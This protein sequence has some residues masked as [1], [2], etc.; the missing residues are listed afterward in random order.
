MQEGLYIIPNDEYSNYLESNLSA[1]HKINYKDFLKKK[2]AYRTKSNRPSKT[3]PDTSVQDPKLKEYKS[4]LRRDR[5]LSIDSVYE[6]STSFDA[7]EESLENSEALVVH[8]QAKRYYFHR[9]SIQSRSYIRNRARDYLAKIKP[10]PLLLSADPDLGVPIDEL[11]KSLLNNTIVREKNSNFADRVAKYQKGNSLTEQGIDGRT[12][13]S[14]LETNPLDSKQNLRYNTLE[15]KDDE[16]IQAY[17]SKT[18]HTIETRTDEGS[19]TRSKQSFVN[20]NAT[21][22]RKKIASGLKFV[23]INT[24]ELGDQ[25]MFNKTQKPQI[26][27]HL[28]LQL[29]PKAKFHAKVEPLSHI[30][31][32]FS[33]LTPIGPLRVLDKPYFTTENDFLPQKTL[34]DNNTNNTVILDLPKPETNS[35]AFHKSDISSNFIGFRQ[36]LTRDPPRFK[37]RAIRDNSLPNDKIIELIMR[38]QE[39]SFEIQRSAQQFP[40]IYPYKSNLRSLVSK[41]KLISER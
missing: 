4:F 28:P 13:A 18:L 38:E 10:K 29:P 33:S 20:E 12:T 6:D 24:S 21:T 25:P 8:P 26:K 19:L 3:Q 1:T 30:T 15:S 9:S 23:N 36:T 16:T 17:C 22:R 11:N 2:T 37:R 35:R 34:T 40:P 14:R 5:E 41:N 39:I 7:Q 32:D 27:P 31:T